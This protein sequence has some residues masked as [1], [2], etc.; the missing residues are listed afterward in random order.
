MRRGY[1]DQS[2]E[3]NW[4]IPQ[5]FDEM[6]TEIWKCFFIHLVVSI[7]L[8]V[9]SLTQIDSKFNISKFSKSFCSLVYTLPRESSLSERV[10]RT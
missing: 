4:V 10:P 6:Y 7:S 1:E 8:K 5:G 2:C 9:S 3:K